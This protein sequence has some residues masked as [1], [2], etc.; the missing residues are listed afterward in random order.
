LYR[1]LRYKKYQHFF[2][3]EKPRPDEYF[4]LAENIAD[5][6]AI[7]ASH[8]AWMAF[9]EENSAELEQKS[10]I[11]MEKFNDEQLFFISSAFVS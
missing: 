7:R 1:S 10:P 6:G 8:R 2:Q 4:T 5:N 9:K 3:G 11:G